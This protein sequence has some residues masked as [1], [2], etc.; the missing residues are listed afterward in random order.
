MIR[1]KKVLARKDAYS[2]MLGV[3]LA[4]SAQSVLF[5]TY[6]WAT[7]LLAAPGA[8]EFASFSTSGQPWQVMYGQPILNFVLQVAVIEA[9]LWLVFGLGQVN[10]NMKPLGSSRKK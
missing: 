4:L 1:I 8:S 5:V 6:N 2:V 9:F 10:K 3:T 7:E